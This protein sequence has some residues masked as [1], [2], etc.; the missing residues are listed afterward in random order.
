MATADERDESARRA[1]MLRAKGL[2]WA[3]VSERL[4]VSERTLQYRVWSLRNGKRRHPQTIRKPD[5]W[6]MLEVAVAY[7]NS[8]RTAARILGINE[9]SAYKGLA[10]WRARQV[11]LGGDHAVG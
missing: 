2:S 3:V 6:R 9:S 5:K 10:R 7:T 1:L 4:G 11:T 8:I